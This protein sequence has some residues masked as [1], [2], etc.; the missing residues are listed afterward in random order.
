MY[1]DLIPTYHFK[2]RINSV[3]DNSVKILEESLKNVTELTVLL[4]TVP[5]SGK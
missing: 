4:P 5:V 1:A 3:V 2:E